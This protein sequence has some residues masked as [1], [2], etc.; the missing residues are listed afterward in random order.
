MYEEW[1]TNPSNV[2]PSWIPTFEAIKNN[3]PHGQIPIP[4]RTS[5][6]VFSSFFS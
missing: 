2:D 3:T 4:E 1:K 6:V 5:K